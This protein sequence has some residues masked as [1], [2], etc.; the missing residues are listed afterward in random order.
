M[1]SGFKKVTKGGGLTIPLEL[2]R[3]LNI[4]PGDTF[5]FETAGEDMI[6]LH[7]YA[8]SCILCESKTDITYY[9]NRPICKCCLA[10]IVE[11]NDKEVA[12]G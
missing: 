5:D 9:N 3:E 7:R 10:A 8:A 1:A 4:N 2:R 11:M 6:V 12:N